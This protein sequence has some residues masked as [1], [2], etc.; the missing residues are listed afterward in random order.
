MKLLTYIA[1]Q[2]QA[3]LYPLLSNSIRRN[4][5]RK[6][7]VQLKFSQFLPQELV[8]VCAIGYLKH[9]LTNCN[10]DIHT[11]SSYLHF[12]NISASSTRIFIVFVFTQK[13]IGLL[14]CIDLKISIIQ[15]VE[16]FHT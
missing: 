2:L 3:A 4:V 15:F 13:T 9:I 16:I 7:G 10:A 12:V 8:L 11:E 6:F 14:R 5:P 1:S